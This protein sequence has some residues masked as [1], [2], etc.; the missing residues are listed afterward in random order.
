MQ[1][2]GGAG[3]GSS[4]LL[5]SR[6]PF[7]LL[8]AL[9]YLKSTRRDAFTTFLSTV[10]VLAIALGVA[11]LI[12]SLAALSG[13]QNLL[14]TEVLARTP[15]IEVELPAGMGP[16]GAVAAA[17]AARAVSGVTAV[18]TVVRGEGWLLRDGRV[19]PSQLVG[20]EGAAPPTLLGV[21]GSGPGLYLSQTLAESWG[22]AAGD[23]V[24][25]VSP[26][27]T[28]TPLGPQPRVRS[29]PY[30][31][32]YAGGRLAEGEVAAV[33]LAV[34][35][36]LFGS[37]RR[38]LLVSA[39]GLEAALTVAEGLTAAMPAGSRVATWR[40]LNRPLFFALRLE[41]IFLFIGVV[42]IVVV[43]ALALLADLSLI[44][45]NKRED[46]GMLL[47]LGATPRALRRA[48][49]GL[50]AL[51]ALLGTALGAAL[52]IGLAIAFDRYRVLR[53]PG[54]VFFVDYIPFLV[55]SQDLGLILAVTLALA[56]A[57]SFYGASKVAAL[58][59]I[60]A[61]RR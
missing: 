13:F 19:V 12:L 21:S 34:A 46:L 58:T 14:R 51:L 29:V 23:V 53:L 50:G 25:V 11:A 15:E 60:E 52:G 56:L 32:A 37:D 48:F 7:S 18:E 39:G 9:R 30:A 47:T 22:L 44:I 45:A 28:L 40:E 3:G 54:D 38:R 36:S 41:R 43:A 33:P 17:A 59:P 6:L 20:F 42:L 57:A 26:R 5:L 31:G 61:M 55:R 35:E 8:L 2:S 27:P 10:A 1:A 24:E 16:E 49:L 4:R